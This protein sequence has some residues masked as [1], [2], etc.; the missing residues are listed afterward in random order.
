MNHKATRQVRF[1]SLKSE[2]SPKLT[3]L[4][5]NSFLWASHSQS[6]LCSKDVSQK[7]DDAHSLYISVS[8]TIVTIKA[9]SVK[10]NLLICIEM[11]TFFL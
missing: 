2:K 11:H 5:V 10:Q 3:L 1:V 8:Q 4:E 9:I 7:K 6:N